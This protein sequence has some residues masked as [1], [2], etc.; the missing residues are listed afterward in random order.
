[1]LDENGTVLQMQRAITIKMV[2]VSCAA[3]IIMAR[4]KP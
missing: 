2:K 1:M 4:N 3:A